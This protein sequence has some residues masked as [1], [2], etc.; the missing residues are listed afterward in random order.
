MDLRR[1]DKG[2]EP[3]KRLDV[4]VNRYTPLT[5]YEIEKLLSL[6]RRRRPMA[7]DFG[8]RDAAERNTGGNNLMAISGD[9]EAF[10]PATDAE[11]RQYKN[12]DYPGWLAS[13][14]TFLQGMLEQLSQLH[15]AGGKAI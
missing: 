9:Q 6:G 1:T 14:E 3:V 2:G 5:H 4:S 10:T 7:I 12:A 8:P 11:I 13:I 15:H